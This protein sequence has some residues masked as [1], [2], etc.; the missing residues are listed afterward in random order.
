MQAARPVTA[1]YAGDVTDARIA[2]LLGDDPPTRR[3]TSG[4]VIFSVLG[5]IAAIWLVMC[6]GQAALAG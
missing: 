4:Q 3:P 6:I 1:A 2:Q 5:L